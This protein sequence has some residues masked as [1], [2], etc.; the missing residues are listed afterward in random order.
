MSQELC[1]KASKYRNKKQEEKIKLNRKNWKGLYTIYLFHYQMER[2]IR[3]GAVRP[4]PPPLPLNIFQPIE[5]TLE[6]CVCLEL[7]HKLEFSC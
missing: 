5:N 1:G 7:K 6:I 2:N 4:P 3:N